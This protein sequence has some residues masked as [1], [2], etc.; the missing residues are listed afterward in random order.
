MGFDTRTTELI[1]IGASVAANCQACLQYHVDKSRETGAGPEE[2]AEAIEVGRMVAKGAASGMKR[3][4]S[5]LTA[6]PSSPD[7]PVPQR[8]GC[9]S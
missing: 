4:A 8:C 7:T 6:A 3:F 5:T 9:P 1:A 2:I